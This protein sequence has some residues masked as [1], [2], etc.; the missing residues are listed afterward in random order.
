V[1]G[2]VVAIPVFERVRVVEGDCVNVF[3]NEVA[4]GEYETEVVALY[5]PVCDRETL[6]VGDTVFELGK[7]VAKG[8]A[9]FDVVGVGDRSAVAVTVLRGVRVTVYISVEDGLPCD[10]EDGVRYVDT[11]VVGVGKLSVNRDIV[12][13]TVDEAHWNGELLLEMLGVVVVVGVIDIIDGDRDA[14]IVTVCV[15]VRREDGDTV[16]NF[17]SEGTALT[18]VLEDV[19][20]DSVRY[21]VDVIDA[22]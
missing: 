3:G 22:L 8:D 18:V 2:F 7:D 21:C 9:L 13:V 12:G 5:R 10:V 14:V 15:A 17:D 11:L 6:G 1:N 4:I 19:E 20:G 16:H